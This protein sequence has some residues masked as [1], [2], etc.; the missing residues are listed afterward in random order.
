MRRNSENYSFFSASHPIFGT[1]L[2]PVFCY[3]RVWTKPPRT[4]RTGKGSAPM[5]APAPATGSVSPRTKRRGFTLIELL[6]VIAIIAILAAILFP[7]FAK[8]R[9]RARQ[10]ACMNNLKQLGLAFIMFAEDNREKLPAMY[11]YFY[12]A[13]GDQWVP[14]EVFKYTK[15]EKVMVCPAMGKA[16][17]ALPNAPPW[18]YTVNGYITV[19]GTTGTQIG[20]DRNKKERVAMGA[21]PSPS[22]TITLVEENRSQYD[23]ETAVNDPVFINVDKASGRHGDKGCVVYLDGHVGTVPGLSRWNSA[24]WPD[25]GQLIFVPEPFN[26]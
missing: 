17:K 16:E 3:N 25:T 9:D 13:S 18:S 19:E 5:T 22:K 24:T 15:T 26:L 6:V 14:G 21:F 11:D 10:T 8:A 7:V 23:Y 20:K 4:F 12:P 2:F 1:E